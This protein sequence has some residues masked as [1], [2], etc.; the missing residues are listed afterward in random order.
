MELSK[1]QKLKNKIEDLKR[2]TGLSDQEIKTLFL[3]EYFLEEEE[4]TKKANDSFVD[5]LKR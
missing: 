3:K 2:E 5:F 4:N 1:G